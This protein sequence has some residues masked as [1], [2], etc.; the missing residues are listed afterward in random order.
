[1]M[2][3]L[4]PGMSDE[5][6]RQ[7]MAWMKDRGCDAAHV[8]L[9]NQ[10]DGECAGWNCSTN[11]DHAKL[12]KKRIRR[13]FLEGFAIVPWVIA[14]D[15]PSYIR[16]LFAHP[17]ERV[18]AL[19]DAR[20]FDHASYVVVGLEMDEAGGGA[21]G[22]PKVAAAIRKHFK[23]K[24]GT[25]HASGNSFRYANLGEIVLGQLEPS[26]ATASAIQHQIAVIRQ[27]GKDAVGF[28]Y[29]RQA[30]RDKAQ[31]A[32]NAGAIGCGNW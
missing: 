5:K 2:N 10:S 16:D 8:F 19:A 29:A 7:Y 17:D 21:T 6:F 11:P 18:K 24:L 20:L 30:N 27:L 12:A 23:G 15:S 25:H 13:L 28:E 32:L 22:W 4:S 9:V 31:A 3:I 26:A 1:M 14:D